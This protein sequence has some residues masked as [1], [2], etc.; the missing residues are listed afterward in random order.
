M[1]R[2]LLEK[3]QQAYRDLDLFPLVEAEDIEKFRI[4][5]GLD[6][7]VRLKREIEASVK[8]GKFV[9]AETEAVVNQH[10]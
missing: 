2:A 9:F 1:D 8:D 6:V 10:C 7:L 4:D 3:F 5:Y